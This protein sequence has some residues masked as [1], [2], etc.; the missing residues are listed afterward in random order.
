MAR[1]LNAYL[2]GHVDVVQLFEPY[3]DQLVQQGQG[4][5]WHRFTQR[6]DIA[7]T[8]FYATR[9]TTQRRR[10]DCLRL[11]AGMARAQKALAAAS[12]A[13]VAKAVAPFLP[14]LAPEALTRIVHSYRL[15]GLWATQPDLP[16]SAFLRLKAALVSGGLIQRDPS[17][18]QVVDEALSLNP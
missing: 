17:Y 15:H 7:Y 18:V 10:D 16:A 1:N 6:G 13:D 4:H 12:A 2:R 9:T 3:A 11:V 14:T 5:V 8:T